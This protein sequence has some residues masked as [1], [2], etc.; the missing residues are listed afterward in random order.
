LKHARNL[1]R[2]VSVEAIGGCSKR[3]ASIYSKAVSSLRVIGAMV[4]Q[5]VFF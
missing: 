5:W 1:G 3:I 2:S 4:K